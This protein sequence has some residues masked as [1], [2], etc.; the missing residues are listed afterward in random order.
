MLCLQS[1]TASPCGALPTGP[2]KKR[3]RF[4]PDGLRQALW[5][6]GSRVTGYTVKL[7]FLFKRG[8]N[9]QTFMSKMSDFLGIA[10]F[11]GLS[12]LFN[13]IPSS[14]S[15][16]IGKWLGET[17]YF[18]PSKR[19][20]VAYADLKAVFGSR[21]SESERWK[22][23]QRNYGYL[24]EIL[25]DLLCFPRMTKESMG[26][27][28]K[29]HHEERYLNTQAKNK[30]VIV[31]TGHF[32]N[33]ELL[34]FVSNVYYDHPVYMIA[35]GQKHNKMNDYL[36]SL[37]SCQGS[38]VITRGKGMGLVA[39]YRALKQNK[40]AGVLGDQDAGK[41]EGIIIP[42]LGRKTTIPTGPFELALKTGAPLFPC[43]LVR[44][45]GPEHELYM[46]DP[47]W[48]DLKKDPETEIKNGVLKFVSLLEGMIQKFP[49]QWLWGTK[50]WKYSWTKRILILADKD[51]TQLNEAKRLTE[52][53]QN[54]KT[55]YGRPGMEYPT[56]TIEVCFKSLWHQRFFGLFV[57]LC[58][59]WIQG[60]LGWLHIFFEPETQK[61][62]REASM[63]FVISGSP[64]L[65][66]LN[67]CLAKECHAKSILLNR[68]PQLFSGHRYDMALEKASD[69]SLENL[70]KIL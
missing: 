40:T 59:P 2:P 3:A 67:L 33:W 56:K 6:T 35:A 16:G 53:F 30:G 9:A 15:V 36:N 47:I 12:T 13:R 28:I 69:A 32:G 22:L 7:D 38:T 49:S 48:C 57:L 31:L 44:T 20:G 63:D 58:L 4:R 43:F 42:L 39:A 66:P 60:R 65:T 51:L 70:E 45:N 5:R 34:Q 19:K 14:V 25:A 24:G 61:A 1:G 50:R 52:M 62:L 10:A 23:I 55:Q 8:Y 27:T 18:I 21:F 41:R 46:E 37:R 68:P 54:V 11:R 29:V 26:K 64:S 17:A